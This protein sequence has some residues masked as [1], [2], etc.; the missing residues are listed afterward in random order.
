LFQ[1]SLVFVASAEEGVQASAFKLEAVKLLDQPSGDKALLQEIRLIL[2]PT[3]KERPTRFLTIQG[4][5]ASL[6]YS[7]ASTRQLRGVRR[8][9]IP[10]W[11]MRLFQKPN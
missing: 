6:K 9:P 8:L 7:F 5:S 11:E 2:K 4:E 1:I 3:D 10:S